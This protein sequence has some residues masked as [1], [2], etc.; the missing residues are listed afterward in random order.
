M[1]FVVSS[2]ALMKRLLHRIVVHVI[3]TARLQYSTATQHNYQKAGGAVLQRP[4]PHR[5]ATPILMLAMAAGQA[6]FPPFRR[7]VCSTRCRFQPRKQVTPPE[8][9]A[10]SVL[11]IA[12]HLGRHASIA[13]YDGHLFEAKSWIFDIERWKQKQA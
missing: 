13:N 11:F 3:S 1:M 6:E 7:Q 2:Q 10:L 5:N 4:S 12:Q 9:Y 8:T